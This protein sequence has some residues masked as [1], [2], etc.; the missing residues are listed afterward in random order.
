[1]G[2]WFGWRKASKPVSSAQIPSPSRA[3]AVPPGQEAVPF[4]SQ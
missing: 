2:G 3:E 4:I 1:M